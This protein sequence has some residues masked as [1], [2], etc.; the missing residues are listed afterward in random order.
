[1][2]IGPVMQLYSRN[3]RHQL[4]ID[5]HHEV[6]AAIADGNGA[7]AKKAIR[8]DIMDGAEF[9]RPLIKFPEGQS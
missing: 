6:V 9:L 5:T 4:T 1:V 2:R 8:Q 3:A 7:E